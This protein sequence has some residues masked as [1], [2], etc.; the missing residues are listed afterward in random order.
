MIAEA[1]AVQPVEEPAPENVEP[2]HVETH[3][4]AEIVEA[5][6]PQPPA[7]EPA[8]EAAAEEP[9]PEPLPPPRAKSSFGSTTSFDRSHAPS[10]PKAAAAEPAPQ[11]AARPYPSTLL[12]TGISARTHQ[13]VRGEPAPQPAPPPPQPTAEKALEPATSGSD[14]YKPWT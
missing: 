12:F 6:E 8:I 2:Q 1:E 9:A 3:T 10:T 7:P 14:I 11:A 5:R 13:T 4:A